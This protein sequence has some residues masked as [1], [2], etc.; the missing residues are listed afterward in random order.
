M[1]EKGFGFSIDQS[2]IFCQT[3]V[4]IIPTIPPTPWLG[5]TSKVSSIS[6][7]CSKRTNCKLL[8]IAA[9]N[10]GEDA[11]ANCHKTQPAGDGYQTNNRPNTCAQR[12]H[13]PILEA[14]QENPS[15]HT[16]SRCKVGIRKGNNRIAI[17]TQS[18]ACIKSK[19]IQ[20]T[21]TLFP[22]LQGD[23]CGRSI[24]LFAFPK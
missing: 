12:G 14:I 16:G 19:T 20:T 6:V 15:H 21:T 8:T 7:L 5:N 2:Y 17:C 4:R 22:K 11:L 1:V 10:P 23:V 13:F 3:P 18:R 9:I 24:F